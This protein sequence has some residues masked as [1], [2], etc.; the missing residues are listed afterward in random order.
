MRQL[1]RPLGV[2][3]AVNHAI[4]VQRSMGECLGTAKTSRIKIEGKCGPLALSYI[5]E[6]RLQHQFEDGPLA[7]R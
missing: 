5:W 2:V 3:N 4:D 1:C 6:P 7:L